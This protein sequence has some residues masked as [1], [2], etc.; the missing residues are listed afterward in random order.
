MEL[1]SKISPFLSSHIKTGDK[2]VIALSGGI[3]SVTLG[4]LLKQWAPEQGVTL[5]AAHLNHG[6]RGDEAREDAVFVEKLMK[7]WGIPCHMGSRDVR[8]F[9]RQQKIS[10]QEAA[11]LCRYEFLEEAA[12][13]EGARWIA[14]GHTADDQVETFIINL[15]RGG[16]TRGL[17]GMEPL[18]KGKILR[19]LWQIWRKEIEA[20]A[21][22][23]NLTFRQDS[24]NESPK[25]LR[26]KIRLE[27]LPYLETKYLSGIKKVLWRNAAIIQEEEHFLE[28]LTRQAFLNCLVEEN[29]ARVILSLEKVNSLLPPLRRRV[30]AEAFRVLKGD[31][32]GLSSYHWEAMER[33]A[34]SSSSGKGLRLPGKVFLSK[35]FE[36]LVF[37]RRGEDREMAPLTIACPGETRASAWGIRVKAEIKSIEDCDMDKAGDYYALLDYERVAAPLT[38]RPWEKGD[39]FR[40]L[41]M[42]GEKKL[43][44]FFTDAKVPLSRRDKIPILTTKDH[45]AWVVGYR[46]DERLKVRAATKEV[47]TV[48][49]RPL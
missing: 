7:E 26:N 13:K 36:H 35:E 37:A 8:T 48:E 9:A 40:P 30:L 44:D 32:R 4:Y 19:P 10:L 11:R 12:R 18:T 38:I 3:D 28:S 17:R 29:P 23:K 20:F 46:I 1:L 22:E 45:I 27:L 34:L 6:L 25:Y 41:G 31:L 5:A 33:L 21:R 2:V 43:Q 15:L 16:G 24:S 39:R 47:L 14:L 49:V 42:R